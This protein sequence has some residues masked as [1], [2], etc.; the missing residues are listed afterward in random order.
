[1]NSPFDQFNA[2]ISSRSG[3]IVYLAYNNTGALTP[4]G[5]DLVLSGATIAGPITANALGL[6]SF[7]VQPPA[8][9]VMVG[10]TVYLQATGIGPTGGA[11][12]VSGVFSFCYCP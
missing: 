8:S 6:G 4:R 2:Y 9:A 5:P 7:S 11:F 1:M 12:D 10:D 3:A